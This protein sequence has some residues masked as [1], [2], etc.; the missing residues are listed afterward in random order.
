MISAGVDRI[1]A[2]NTL[3]ASKPGEPAGRALRF[4]S[5][6]PGTTG[7]GATERQ[8]VAHALGSGALSSVRW[9]FVRAET[10]AKG[11]DERPVASAD[12][13]GAQNPWLPV[14]YEAMAR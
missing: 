8:A 4:F 2:I 13:D 9:T 10:N 7:R 11:L 3:L 1:I 14:S 6:I 5:W 12:W